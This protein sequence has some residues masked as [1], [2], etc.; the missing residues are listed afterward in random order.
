MPHAIQ[1]RAKSDT[2]VHFHIHKYRSIVEKPPSSGAKSCILERVVATRGYELITP[3]VTPP[4]GANPTRSVQ[5]CRRVVHHI[6]KTGHKK[7]TTTLA[8][9][10][11]QIKASNNCLISNRYAIKP[12]RVPLVL[13]EVALLNMS[14]LCFVESSSKPGSTR[15]LFAKLLLFARC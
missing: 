7:R 3:Q 9:I 13:E 11:R 14:A 1:T 2:H 10:P 4:R 8:A 6:E 5:Q 15:S 12:Q